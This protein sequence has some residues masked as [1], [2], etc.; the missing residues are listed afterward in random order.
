MKT[1]LNVIR[2]PK[3][4]LIGFWCNVEP[5]ATHWHL[6]DV[7][8]DCGLLLVARDRVHDQPEDPCGLRLR[9]PT[10]FDPEGDDEHWL[11][12]NNRRV[13]TRN[14][15]HYAALKELRPDLV[16][17]L[18]SRMHPRWPN[19]NTFSFWDKDETSVEKCFSDL[20]SR[21][22]E[23]VDDPRRRP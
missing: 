4:D 23:R 15:N 1:P 18:I 20:T 9:S 2:R 19:S 17:L 21:E 22:G 10:L 5:F 12:V 3:D 14:L 8:E 16:P 11:T 6:F 13:F 7:A